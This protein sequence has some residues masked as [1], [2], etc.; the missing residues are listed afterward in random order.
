MA[1]QIIDGPSQGPWKHLKARKSAIRRALSS[2]AMRNYQTLPWWLAMVRLDP[3][4]PYEI[5]SL[6]GR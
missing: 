2:A 4:L 1:D 5:D 6:S 3:E